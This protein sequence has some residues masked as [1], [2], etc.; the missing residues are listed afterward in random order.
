MNI[1]D[2]LGYT[3]TH[4]WARIEGDIATFGITDYAQSMLGDIVSVELPEV[5]A[6]F[7]QADSIAL[8]DS[9]KATSDFYA[10]LS[11][12]VIE[13]NQALEESPELIN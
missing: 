4:E 12:E 1:P 7:S 11:G 2:S 5:G 6:T 8:I 9:M 3:K 10:P 13:V